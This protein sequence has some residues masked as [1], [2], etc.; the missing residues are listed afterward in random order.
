MGFG[1]KVT[2]R[3]G[4]GMFIEWYEENYGKVGRER[5]V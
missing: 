1:P 4:L 3:E 5:R 2:I